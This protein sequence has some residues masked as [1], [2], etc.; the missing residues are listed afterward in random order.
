[1]LLEQ[2]VR[3]QEAQ[4]ALQRRIARD[5]AVVAFSTSKRADRIASEGSRTIGVKLP[6]SVRDRIIAQ[7]RK[8][9]VGCYS[10]TVA[11]CAELGLELLETAT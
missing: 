9:G 11:L 10:D 6:I 5:G 3:K 4:R 1:M 2:I 7:Q 8:R